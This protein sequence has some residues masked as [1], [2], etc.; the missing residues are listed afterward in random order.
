MRILF[1]PSDCIL[2]QV[3]KPV[4]YRDADVDWGSWM[5]DSFPTT[6]HDAM[7]YWMTRENDT[8]ILYEFSSRD[9]FR[10]KN[11]SRT[12]NLPFEFD[13]NSHVVYDGSFYYNEFESNRIIK[14]DLTSN[15]TKS[16]VIEDAAHSPMSN[17]LFET[18]YN[19]MDLNADENGLWVIFATNITNNT[20]VLKFDPATLLTEN[21]WNLTL[22]HQMMGEMFIACGVLYGVE[23]TTDT[24]TKIRF[25]FDLY[26]NTPIEISVNFTNPFKQNTMISY[27]PRYEQIYSWDSRNLIVYPIRFAEDFSDTNTT[28]EIDDSGLIK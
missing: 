12:Y 3:G 2:N 25:A 20:L 6:A 13:G 8:N 1:F 14:L 10:H 28:E 21:L 19:Y 15:K 26:L 5:Q 11:V 4:Y 16:R 24:F 7:K 17:H 9:R 22:D 27:N 18:Q 23:S